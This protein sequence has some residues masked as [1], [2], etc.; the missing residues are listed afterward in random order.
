MGKI[1]DSD[2]FETRDQ[3]LA[4]AARERDLPKRARGNAERGL[5]QVLASA[6]LPAGTVAAEVL[7]LLPDAFISEYTELFHRALELD[8]GLG[9]EKAG[10]DEGKIKSRVDS[11]YVGKRVGAAGKKGGKKYR[12]GWVVKD[13]GALEVKRLIDRRLRGLGRQIRRELAEMR[14]LGVEEYVKVHRCP[15]SGC[16]RFVEPGWS[17]CAGCGQQLGDE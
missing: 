16:Q 14:E 10:G 8:G 4:R 7:L 2:G 5:A 13:E 12:N 17:Y 15:R 11:R 3:Q 9:K 6:G 1:T